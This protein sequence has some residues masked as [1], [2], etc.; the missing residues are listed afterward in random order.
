MRCGQ[1]IKTLL[2]SYQKTVLGQFV[3]KF[4]LR[5]GV[6][7]LPVMEN[8]FKLIFERKKFLTSG[9]NGTR[10]W[11]VE[12]LSSFICGAFMDTTVL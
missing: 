7:K 1:C 12:V 9:Q 8:M 10:K 6:Q 11:V 4:I 2:L 5:V 3:K